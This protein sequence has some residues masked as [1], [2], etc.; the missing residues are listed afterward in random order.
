MR[1]P[2]R[3]RTVIHIPATSSN[4]SDRA[5]VRR[6]GR[7]SDFSNEKWMQVDE[8]SPPFLPSLGGLS[9]PLFAPSM[10]GGMDGG[11]GRGRPGMRGPQYPASLDYD[12]STGPAPPS[13]GLSRMPTNSY[14]DAPKNPSSPPGNPPPRGYGPN[15]ASTPDRQRYSR[16]EKN[17]YGPYGPSGPI[18]PSKGRP[19]GSSSNNNYGPP[20]E[21]FYPDYEDGVPRYSYNPS[22]IPK[23]SKESNV[24]Y[25]I[26]DQEYPM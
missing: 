14:Y 22:E 11:M 23:C 6:A 1:Q 10:A 4:Y 9:F 25:C 5:F 20:P 26:E 21:P 16:P 18:N 12:R 7:F 19:K 13:E 3:S 15:P 8:S 17:K 2:W 24:S